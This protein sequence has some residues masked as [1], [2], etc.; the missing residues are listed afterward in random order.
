LF[1]RTKFNHN[2]LLESLSGREQLILY[3][4]TQRCCSEIILRESMQLHQVA[5]TVT[6]NDGGLIPPMKAY[7]FDDKAKQI[8]ADLYESFRVLIRY[9]R[10]HGAL[11]PAGVEELK[12]LVQGQYFIPALERIQKYVMQ[13]ITNTHRHRAVEMLVQTWVSLCRHCAF[14]Y[15]LAYRGLQNLR[16]FH[17]GSEDVKRELA[18]QIEL[19]EQCAASQRGLIVIR[20]F[21]Q[22][23]KPKEA[24]PDSSQPTSPTREALRKLEFQ[25]KAVSPSLKEIEFIPD[26][27]RIS[28]GEI[29]FLPDV[30]TY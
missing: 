28:A 29:Q 3:A 22:R 14:Q 30:P 27:P 24:Q 13:S 2:R 26:V 17:V 12:Q 23:L 1:I 18:L 15:K 7:D 25:P 9:L 16:T 19:A 21:E 20:A 5:S 6:S 8:L 4:Y 10:G 11:S